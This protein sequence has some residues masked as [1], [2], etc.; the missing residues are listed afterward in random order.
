MPLPEAERAPEAY[1]DLIDIVSSY[2]L[3]GGDFVV[4]DI[5][6]SV[7]GTAGMLPADKRSADVVR[8]RVHP[9]MRRQGIG[10]ALLEAI[11]HRAIELNIR[12][13]NLDVEENPAG[14]VE[15]YLSSGFQRIDPDDDESEH[16]WD[17]TMFSKPLHHS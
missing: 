11:E 9:A 16:R 10:T 8:V 1:P 14:A 13:L 12:T 4:A 15:F 6:G 7:V 2:V 17:L 5:D 3:S